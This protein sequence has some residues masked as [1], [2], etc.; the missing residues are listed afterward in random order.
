MILVSTADKRVRTVS[1]RP[2]QFGWQLGTWL[3]WGWLGMTPGQGLT[4]VR[5]THSS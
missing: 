2:E 1:V 4:T 3:L 5:R